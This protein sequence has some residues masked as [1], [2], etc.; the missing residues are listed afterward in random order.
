MQHLQYSLVYFVYKAQVMKAFHAQ[1]V[2]DYSL[3]ILLFPI[4]KI[5]LHPRRY[6][7]IFLLHQFPQGPCAGSGRAPPC[8][9][10]FFVKKSSKNFI[11]R[12]GGKTGAL[13]PSFPYCPARQKDGGRRGVVQWSLLSP[14]F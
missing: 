7:L 8:T 1:A 11:S 13:L 3:S 5:S 4:S 9:R 2:P 12:C 14:R 6:R 10:D